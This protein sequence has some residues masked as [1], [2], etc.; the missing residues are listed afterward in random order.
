MRKR[1]LIEALELEVLRLSDLVERQQAQIKELKRH[2]LLWI[3]AAVQIAREQNKRT[4][5]E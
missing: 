5:E 2:K 1:K 3:K 4:G